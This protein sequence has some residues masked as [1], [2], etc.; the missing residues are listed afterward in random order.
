MFDLVADVERYHEFVPLCRR[1]VIR[2]REKRGELEILIT[3]MTVAYA[4]VSETV[5]SRVTLDR[6][7]RRILVEGIG[8]PLRR[9]RTLW[10]FDPRPDGTCDVDFDLSY[11]FASRALALLMGAVFEAAFSRFVEAFQRRADAVY[12]GE[13]PASTPN[14]V[15]PRLRGSR[16]R[17]RG[18][19]KLSA[20]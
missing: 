7:N 5:R 10:T 20:L 11:E 13:P 1:H 12:G 16:F 18:S 15:K 9:L 8:G 3:D 19:S 6:A 17:A 2:S 14:A 4:F